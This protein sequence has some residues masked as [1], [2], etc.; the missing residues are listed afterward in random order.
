MEVAGPSGAAKIGPQYVRFFQTLGVSD[1][2]KTQTLARLLKR[3]YA[4]A[5]QLDNH[6]T[7]VC[8]SLH[9]AVSRMV[10]TDNP[11]APPQYRWIR[12][13]DRLEFFGDAD[14]HAS[15]LVNVGLSYAYRHQDLDVIATSN[16][17]RLKD[18]RESE[19]VLATAGAPAQMPPPGGLIVARRPGPPASA[20]G[21]AR[22]GGPGA[23]VV[24]AGVTGDGGAVA[25][26]AGA[27]GACAGGVG[28]GGAGGAQTNVPHSLQQPP[29][30]GVV[31]ARRLGPPGPSGG[32]AG[33]GGA[34]G[35]A[36]MAPHPP[37]D[38]VVTLAL[39]PGGVVVSRRGI[40]LSRHGTDKAEAALST[41]AKQAAAGALSAVPA[42][43]VGIGEGGVVLAARV[44]PAAE[45][46]DGRSVVPAS[47][48]GA[49]ATLSS[50]RSVLIADDASAEVVSTSRPVVHPSVAATK[51]VNNVLN[52]MK[53]RKDVRGVL[54]QLVIDSLLCFS[55]AYTGT[56]V[57][58]STGA[59]PP[60]NQVTWKSVRKIVHRWWPIWQ[61]PETTDKPLPPPGTVSFLSH[62]CRRVRYSRWA[63]DVEMSSVADA[64]GE[65]KVRIDR[66][67]DKP[68]VPACESVS[69]IG[70][71]NAN[72]VAPLGTSVATML[73][74]GTKEDSFCGILDELVAVGRAPVPRPVPMLAA[75]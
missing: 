10:E 71:K 17:V 18:L 4:L 55:R 75:T 6:L 26:G 44:P 54:E 47:G 43:S 66:R 49:T 37:S 39:P 64:M 53:V 29:I 24:G 34:A 15:R 40:G 61:A 50:V 9:S 35:T 51:C 30:G 33:A 74:I 25:G 42:V 68:D 46:D 1:G 22:A 5:A 48:G 62:P 41:T 65:L 38:A 70:P 69:R 2:P 28:A 57:N 63:I 56:A 67:F 7:P 14:D 36:A 11:R 45:A 27:G 19:N 20:D 60:D 52:L 73:L 8:A 32:E 13:V 16:A 59:L 31:V 21:H 12:I 3:F 72:S 58:M 23:G